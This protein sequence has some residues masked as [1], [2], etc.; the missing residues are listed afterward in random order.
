MTNGITYLSVT[1]IAVVF[2]VALGS[3]Y[4]L[5]TNNNNTIPNTSNTNS[6]NTNST[7]NTTNNT[8]N[9]PFQLN[10][11][12]TSNNY[13][14]STVGYQ[15]AFFVLVNGTL[16]TSANIDVPA[17]QPITLTIHNFDNISYSVA[18]SYGK[19][20]TGT[21]TN[22][23]LIIPANQSKL[24]V[25]SLPVNDL[26]QTFTVLNNNHAISINIPIEPSSLI[27]TTIIFPQSGDFSWQ[28]FVPCGSGPS[29]WG[30][31]M[32]TPGWLKGTVVVS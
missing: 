23:M 14:N 32:V 10:L 15:P 7:N 29:G 27:S 2:I 18:P 20:I 28:C 30:G 22:E 3:G 26:S 16:E 4:Y 11:M 8:N 17:N 9:T 1:A 31:A 19:V 5:G 6:T 25:T 12:I 13:Y 24:Y 21:G